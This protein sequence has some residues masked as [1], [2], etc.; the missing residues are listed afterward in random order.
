MPVAI[1]ST[2]TF[3]A[4]DRGLDDCYAGKRAGGAKREGE[5]DDFI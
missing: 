4:Q 5:A 2:P 1:L 3:D